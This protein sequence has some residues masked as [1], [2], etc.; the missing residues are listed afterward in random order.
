MKPLLA[1]NPSDVQVLIITNIAGEVILAV[2]LPVCSN[3]VDDAGDN[4]S[5]Y[6]VAI[7]VTP[8]GNRTR[9]NSGTSGSKS[10]LKYLCKNSRIAIV[11]KLHHY[12]GNAF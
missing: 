12:A 7:E 2:L 5:K 9:H 8:L 4:D 11:W 1:R 6:D 3:G 10:R